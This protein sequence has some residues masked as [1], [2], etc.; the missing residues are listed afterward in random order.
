MTWFLLSQ[1]MVSNLCFV[2]IL[3][4]I[5]TSHGSQ[6]AFVSNDLSD[7]RL[8]SKKGRKSKKSKKHVSEDSDTKESLKVRFFIL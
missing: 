6:S 2:L 5:A 3:D 4:V 8:K 1:S 7:R